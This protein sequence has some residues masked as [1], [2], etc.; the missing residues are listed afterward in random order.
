M[1]QAEIFFVFLILILTLSFIPLFSESSNIN[2]G[3]R[4]KEGRAAPGWEFLMFEDL[5]SEK[6][7]DSPDTDS[8]DFEKNDL[9]NIPS[10]RYI[11]EKIEKED[12]KQ[13]SRVEKS[14]RKPPVKKH[15]QKTTHVY[16][17]KHEVSDYSRYEKTPEK[18]IPDKIQNFE[19]K[20]SKTYKSQKKLLD[21]ESRSDYDNYEE[22]E[23]DREKYEE[24][25]SEKESEMRKKDS[26]ENIEEKHKERRRKREEMQK[27][28]WNRKF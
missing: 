25:P 6:D 13:T 15:R 8:P 2:I 20:N 17:D 24:E 7:F 26:L 27:K 4:V 12:K 22:I 5:L 1:K 19:S 16:D 21:I 10:D 3:V 9:A 11:K 28:R 14:S 18:E 23:K